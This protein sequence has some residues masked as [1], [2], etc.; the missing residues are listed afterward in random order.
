MSALLRFKALA[1]IAAFCIVYPTFLLSQVIIRERVEIKPKQQNASLGPSR[2]TTSTIDY[3]NPPLFVLDYEGLPVLTLPSSLTISGQVDIDGVLGGN[4]KATVVLVLSEYN[5]VE[6][7]WKG[8]E[9]IPSGG[10]MYEGKNPYAGEFTEGSYPDV[11]LWLLGLS[12]WGTGARQIV[13]NENELQYNFS[14]YITPAVLVTAT[15]SATGGFLSGVSFDHWD[16]LAENLTVS[17]LDSTAIDMRP[18]N[19][20]GGEYEPAELDPAE[21][22]VT[23]RVDADGD[24]VYLAYTEYQF[25]EWPPTIVYHSGKEISM[26]LMYWPYL[27]Y[28]GSRGTFNG[29]SDTVYVTVTGGGKSTTI[30]VVLRKNE[31]LLGE[32]KYYY[33]ANVDG[34]PKIKA[35]TSTAVPDDVI[36][37]FEWGDEPVKVVETASNSGRKLGTYWERGKP[38]PNASGNL[39]DALIRLIGR[40]W[41]ADSVYE[42]RLSAT[43][44]Y[45]ETVS[46]VIEVE[47]PEELLDRKVFSKPYALTWNIRNERLDIDSLCIVNA[48]RIG[49]SPQVVK[50]QMFQESDKANERFNPSYRYE[51]WKDYAF[52]HG[53][54]A[55]DYAKQPFWVTGG[56]LN[57]MGAGKSVPLDH[58]NVKPVYYQTTPVSIADYAISNWNQYVFLAKD[59]IIGSKQLT[60]DFR[61]YLEIYKNYWL[62]PFVGEGQYSLATKCIQRDIRQKY[63]DYAQTR[64]AASFGLIQMLYTT[65]LVQGYND[66]RSISTSQAPEELNDETVEMPF[67]RAFTEKNLRLQFGSQTARVPG[68]NWPKGWER[69]WMDSFKKYNK[70]PSYGVEVLDHARKFSPQKK[71]GAL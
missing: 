46:T 53:E 4:Q 13:V 40:Y 64:K 50:A 49:I 3:F 69:T 42:V 31:I 1:A 15:A 45:G 23:V 59:S 26:S 10:N 24:Y 17:G 30:P 57:P 37:D 14:G 25:D 36:P 67:Y 12:G 63:T 19:G 47:K 58:Q 20:N 51:P 33:V 52:A 22:M 21:A 11:Q 7:A 34:W 54:Y 68:A 6:I 18:L 71:Q 35:T 8:R 32:T 5:Q 41:S 70:A 56:Q 66:G 9:P 62:V 29:S 61:R 39:P 2:S 16:V 28:D 60:L 38:I 48:G 55:E 43:D 65:A 27:V 44:S